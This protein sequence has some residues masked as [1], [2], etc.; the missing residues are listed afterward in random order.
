MYFILEICGN[1]CSVCWGQNV[2]SP[3]PVIH[4]RNFR[5]SRDRWSCDSLRSESPLLSDQ[6]GPTDRTST[7]ASAM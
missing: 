7:S 3:F 4:G 6:E 2:L 1:N 5:K